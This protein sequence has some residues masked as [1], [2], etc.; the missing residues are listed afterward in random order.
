MIRRIVPLVLA[1]ALLTGC[2]APVETVKKKQ[3]QATFL[4]L[5]DT[6][7]TII[8]YGKTEE[9]FKEVTDQIHDELEIYHQLSLLNGIT[10][11]LS[12]NVH[13][14]YTDR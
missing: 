9:E 13:S 1:I 10:I 8:G 14:S 12:Q 11:P 6:V 3:Y 2:S 7:T 4:T 5:F